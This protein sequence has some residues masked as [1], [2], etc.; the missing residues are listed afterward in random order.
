MAAA[1]TRTSAGTEARGKEMRLTARGS[2]SQVNP[3]IMNSRGTAKFFVN[4]MPYGPLPEFYELSG[5]I[6]VLNGRRGTHPC[7]DAAATP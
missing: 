7:A 4:T 6:N 5:E 2:P 3:F 1:K